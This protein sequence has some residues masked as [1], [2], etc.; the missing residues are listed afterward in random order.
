MNIG[1][2]AL[3]TF[4]PTTKYLEWSKLFQVVEVVSLD[5]S[6]C[7]RIIKDLDEDDR[8]YQQ[9]HGGT[10]SDIINNLDWLLHKTRNVEDKQVL[11]VVK[12][13]ESDCSVAIHPERFQFCGYDLVEDAT[14]ISALTNCGGFDKAFSAC[15][16]SRYGLIEDFEKAKEIQ[17]RLRA[18]YP[19]EEDANCTL[20]AIWKMVA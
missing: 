13:P 12:E 14:R 8:E 19:D 20:W 16:I 3:E 2:V 15:E 1:F 4:I 17:L 6:L 11:A 7:P 9:E 18:H 10:Y 5:S